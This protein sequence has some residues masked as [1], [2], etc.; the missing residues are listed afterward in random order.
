MRDQIISNAAILHEKG[1][2]IAICTDHPEVPAQYLRMSAALAV[3]GGL[4]REAA[5]RAITSEA[6][7]IIGA[8]ERIGRIAVGLDADLVLFKDDP[9]DL[10]QDPVWVMIDGHFI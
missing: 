7:D 9:L 10:M 1:C 3:K 4:S 8:S 6:A 5:L 2:H